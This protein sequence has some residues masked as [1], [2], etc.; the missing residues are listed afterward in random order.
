M[1]IKSLYDENELLAKVAAG[2]QRAFRILYE[3]YYRKVYTQA[4]R[5][6]RDSIAGEE[7]LQEVFLKLWRLGPGLTA[8]HN[9]DNYLKTT[10]RNQGL[11]ALR[12]LALEAKGSR[13]IGLNYTDVHNETEEGILLN[14]TRRILDAAIDRL[15]KQQR[16]V[17]QLCHQEGLKY[18][19]AAERLNLSPLTVQTHMKRA[20]KSLRGYLQNHTEVAIMLIIVNHISR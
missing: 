17:Y 13:A 1:A 16:E 11:N 8:I 6:M 20:L 19:Q 9:L 14:D 7:I 2:D 10:T 15:P 12:R 4:S 18:E 5:L 3:S